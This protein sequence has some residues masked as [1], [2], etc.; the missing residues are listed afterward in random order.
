MV[1]RC[2]HY[3]MHSGP[4]KG[5]N[6]VE[7]WVSLGESQ[8]A[9]VIHMESQNELGRNSLENA[10]SKVCNSWTAGAPQGCFFDTPGM[11]HCQGTCPALLEK[12]SVNK[13]LA[14]AASPLKFR[15]VVG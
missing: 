11:R 15:E 14:A 2:E 8:Q 10:Q 4:P 7:G 6:R 12:Y 1:L 9:A 3:G 13:S 5:R